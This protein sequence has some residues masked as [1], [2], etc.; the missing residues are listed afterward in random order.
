MFVRLQQ[1]G[2]VLIMD[3]FWFGVLEVESLGH[4]RTATRVTPQIRHV[5]G[6]LAL[7]LVRYQSVQISGPD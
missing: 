2:L 6:H 1:Y 4:S 7:S 3:E 5:K